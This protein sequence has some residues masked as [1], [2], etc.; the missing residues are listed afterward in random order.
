MS[1]DSCWNVIR[2]RSGPALLTVL[3]AV[4]SVAP[5]PAGAQ[6]PQAGLAEPRSTT[7]A[8]R[9]QRL[10]ER[11]LSV[12]EARRL[13]D[14][15][16]SEE[17]IAVARRTVSIER[18]L[19]GDAHPDVAR[20]LELLAEIAQRFARFEEAGASLREALA[21]RTKARGPDHWLSV[22]ARY[23]LERNDRLIGLDET[24]REKYRAAQRVLVQADKLT[25]VQELE[26]CVKLLFEA[27]EL[28]R[29]ALGES[30]PEFAHCLERFARQRVMKGPERGRNDET[31]KPV[32]AL[33]AQVQAIRKQALGER[34][35]DYAL[36]LETRA[37]RM[38]IDRKAGRS[39]GEPL[40]R[41]ALE[42]RRAAQ[43]EHHPAYAHTLSLLAKVLQLQAGGDIAEAERLLLRAVEIEREVYGADSLATPA[44]VEPSESIVQHQE[45][46]PGQGRG[47]AAGGITDRAE[48]P[49]RDHW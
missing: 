33:Y 34:H 2:R 21:I 16:Y 49:R 30:H 25:L 48:V 19:F 4:G 32:F 24:R 47:L 5:R 13:A 12:W 6:P 10:R 15:V 40:L 35:P 1:G 36:S 45:R 29:Q 31:N 14:E 20:A 8:P 42:I 22:D 9:E 39:A 43:G 27:L 38:P 46:R 7:A 23:A 26:K 18:E 3:L 11:D 17:A 41:Q 37:L 28:Q 44:H